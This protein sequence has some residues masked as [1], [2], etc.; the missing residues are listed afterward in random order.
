MDDLTDVSNSIV[1]D[2]AK[3]GNTADNQLQLRLQIA[4]Q[5][6]QTLTTG[7]AGAHQLIADML[8]HMEPKPTTT[9]TGA[10]PAFRSQVVKPGMTTP[11]AVGEL[12]SSSRRP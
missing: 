12:K 6:I 5:N 4:E 3:R 9:T 8:T 1:Y 10:T 2:L 11:A 7:L